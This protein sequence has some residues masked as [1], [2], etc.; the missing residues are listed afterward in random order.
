MKKRL[1]ILI[2]LC[3]F[4][5]SKLYCALSFK[6]DS[7]KHTENKH[8]LGIE[9]GG[10]GLGISLNM[11]SDF[12]KTKIGIFSGVYGVTFVGPYFHIHLVFHYVCNTIVNQNID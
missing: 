1:C 10:G 4:L 7:L 3:C 12:A 9:L 2:L 8:S 11:Q 6:E 5:S